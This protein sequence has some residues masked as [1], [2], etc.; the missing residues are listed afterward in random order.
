MARGTTATKVNAKKAA[1]AKAASAGAPRLPAPSSNGGGRSVGIAL[2][3]IDAFMGDV[4]LGVSELARRTNV[5]KSSVSRTCAHLVARGYL[6][7]VG[8]GRFRLGMHLLELGRLVE[9]RT[10][11]GSTA[12]EILTGLAAAVRHTVHLGVPDGGDVVFVER[13]EATRHLRYASEP[14]RRSPAHRSSCGK[15]LAAFLPEV[16]DARLRAG[17]PARTGYTIVVPELL[18]AELDRVRE[19]G[20]AT[21]VE[22]TEIGGAS[23]AVPVRNPRTRTVVAALAVAGPTQQVVPDEAHLVELLRLAARRLESAIAKGQLVVPT[24]VPSSS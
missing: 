16:L 1:P 14:W 9:I 24:S 12:L 18:V 23:L 22:E 13:V 20:Y 2:D 6:D 7:R 10:G 3:L 15:V 5:A 11:L 4:E 17:L 21:N 8:P 19:R